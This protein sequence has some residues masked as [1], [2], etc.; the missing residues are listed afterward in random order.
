M[1][2]SPKFSKDAAIK[3]SLVRQGGGGAKTSKRKMDNAL[4]DLAAMGGAGGKTAKRR[5][6]S[7][8]TGRDSFMP[9]EKTVTDTVKKEFGVGSY[10]KNY[11]KKNS[12]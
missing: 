12:K 9:M 2:S 8:A 11:F 10:A 6:G 3:R 7:G 1:P 4:K 5:Y